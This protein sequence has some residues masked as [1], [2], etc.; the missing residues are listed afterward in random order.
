MKKVLVVWSEIPEDIARFILLDVKDSMVEKL[1]RFHGEYLNCCQDKKLEKEIFDFFYDG[2]SC[3][4][5]N[6]YTVCEPMTTPVDLVIAC[7]I[8]C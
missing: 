4:R 7:G 1:K 5:F 6:Y 3:F 2:P 8:Y